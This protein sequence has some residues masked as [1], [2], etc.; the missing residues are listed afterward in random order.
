MSK[1]KIIYS[2]HSYLLTQF[3]HS[4]YSSKPIHIVNIIVICGI[5]E[6]CSPIYLDLESLDTVSIHFANGVQCPDCVSKLQVSRWNVGR[7]EG[8]CPR[9]LHNINYV[10]ILLPA[11][12]ECDN[13]H[14]VVSTDP[15]ILRQFPEE[16][17]IPFILF[18]R[19]GITR[20][21]ARCTI[22]L[23]LEG[24]TFAVIERFIQRRRYENI[25]SL[26]LK[27][28]C[29]SSHIQLPQ[30]DKNHSID[31]L[32]QSYLSNDILSRCFL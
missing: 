18:H 7:S 13:K 22:G 27:V 32:Y 4:H 3:I 12:Y 20:E 24:L 31:H 25:A 17:Y 5:R 9:L 21:F 8:H 15:Y 19:S 1:I 6:H 2:L 11:V 28:N 16:E 29:I 23:A 26:Q 30:L 10:I 14:E